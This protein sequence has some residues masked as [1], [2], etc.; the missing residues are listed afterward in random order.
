[1]QHALQPD[2][3]KRTLKPT[4]SITP[5]TPPHHRHTSSLGDSNLHVPPRREDPRRKSELVLAV[6]PPSSPS[7]I[8]PKRPS[9]ARAASTPPRTPASPSNSAVVQCSGVT[10]AGN[11]CKKQVKVGE[12]S[13]DDDQKHFCHQH[14]KEVLSPTGTFTRKTGEWIKFA[15]WIPNYL[16]EDTQIALREEMDKARSSSDRPGYIY[17]YEIR[18]PDNPGT[19]KLKVGRAVNLIKRIDEWGKQCGSKEQVLRGFYPGVVEDGLDGDD[20]GGTFSLMKGRVRPGEKTSCCHR[21]ERL[22]H[23]ELND[24]V[25][26]EVHLQPGWPSPPAADGAKSPKKAAKKDKCAD[27]GQTHKEIFEFTRFAGGRYKNKEFDSIVRPVIE[28]WGGF[29][30]ACV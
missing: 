30:E 26:R 14:A 9:R 15:D 10:K 11:R 4:P 7:P 29:V 1:M 6:S 20:A 8:T 16:H 19:V 17:T 2:R 28:K 22:I 3:A 12:V 23:L 27:C 18:D 13:L 24:L 25:T 21:L 5:Y